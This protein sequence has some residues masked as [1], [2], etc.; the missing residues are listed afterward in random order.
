MPL[1]PICLAQASASEQVYFHL[2]HATQAGEEETTTGWIFIRDPILQLPPTRTLAQ[3]PRDGVVIH[4]D[5]SRSWPTLKEHTQG[6]W[7]IDVTGNRLVRY[8]ISSGKLT[9]ALGSSRWESTGWANAALGAAV[10][11]DGSGTGTCFENINDTPDK[12]QCSVILTGPLAFNAK[13]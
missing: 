11:V 6:G 7:R 10:F 5:L 12:T 13:P 8:D 9:Y 4:V 1:L 3:L 2:S